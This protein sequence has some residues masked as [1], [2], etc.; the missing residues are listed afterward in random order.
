MK[1]CVVR[2]KFIPDIQNSIEEGKFYAMKNFS[3]QNPKPTYK[4]LDDEL[5]VLVDGSTYIE[6]IIE[7]VPQIPRYK[8]RFLP[9]EDIETRAGDI[10]LLI[11]NFREHAFVKF[12]V[13]NRT[14]KGIY[15]FLLNFLEQC[16]MLFY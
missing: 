7:D 16:D 9:F 3:L 15:A 10:S 4:L 6:E 11:G 13:P 1:H 12:F 2:S 14:E 8:F 5:Q